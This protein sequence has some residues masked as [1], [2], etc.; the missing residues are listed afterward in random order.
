LYH[1]YQRCPT[2]LTNGQHLEAKKFG[3]QIFGSKAH[4]GHEN[5]LLITILTIDITLILHFYEEFLL[6]KSWRAFE[7]VFAGIKMPAG[8]RLGTTDL[9]QGWPTH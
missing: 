8:T 7:K 6:Q 1:L 4:G 3:G 9:Y 5:T 2:F